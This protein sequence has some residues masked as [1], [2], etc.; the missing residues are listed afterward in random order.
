MVAPVALYPGPSSQVVIGGTAVIAVYPGALWATITN[1]STAEDQGLVAGVET[2]FYDL[3]HPAGTAQSPT[4]FPLQPGA[5]ITIPSTTAEVTVNAKSSG[6]KFS[7]IVAQPAPLPPVPPT[8]G[9]FPPDGPVTM[10][11]TIP[12]YLY[13]QYND[14]DDLQAFVASYNA[15]TQAYVD[16]F[17]SVNL[18]IYTGLE[19]L[20]LDWVAQGLYGLTRPSLSSGQN[21]DIGP[22]DSFMFNQVAYNQRIVV[23]PSNIIATSDDIFQR[24]IT[25]DWYKG[26]GRVFNIRWLK[27]R[28]MRFI[29]G[30]NGTAPL[31]NNTWQVSVTFGIGNQVSIKLLSVERILV[32][33]ALYGGFMFN[34]M[35]YNFFETEVDFNFPPLPNAATMVEAIESGAVELP[36]QLNFVA[37]Q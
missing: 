18:P 19:G 30:V 6:H 8:P 33:G 31:I 12:S 32:E 9:P 36:F 17:N 7:V 22:Y 35:S 23:G 21:N 1:P 4:T 34:Q 16:W 24:I 25:W 13:V 3:V 27:R 14:D 29:L 10:L 37:S 15:M 26:D 11:T 2:L 5:S 20:L 28:I